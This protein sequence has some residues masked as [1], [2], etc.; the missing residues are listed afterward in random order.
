MQIITILTSR[1]RF[2]QICAFLL[3]SLL[4]QNCRKD[5]IVTGIMQPVTI[6]NIFISAGNLPDE[7]Q[8]VLSFI[9]HENEKY[10]FLPSFI[11]RFGIP[12]W[13]HSKVIESPQS[14]VPAFERS[15]GSGSSSPII[16]QQESIVLIPFSLPGS[17]EIT[18]YLVSKVRDSM[19]DGV[20]F[21][22]IKNSEIFQSAVARAKVSKE[23]FVVEG[24]KFE[25]DMFG[26]ESFQVTDRS[27]FK[28]EIE[29][30]GK[31]PVLIQ[32][33][34]TE[35][36]STTSK[37]FN[38]SYWV[39][40]VVSICYKIWVSRDQGQLVG[41]SV[42]C[43]SAHHYKEVTICD[44][45]YSW[46]EIVDVVVGGGGSSVTQWWYTGACVNGPCGASSSTTS[47]NTSTYTSTVNAVASKLT[48][49]DSQREW[50]SRN[51]WEAN[52]IQSFLM[53]DMMAQP[54]IEEDVYAGT[55]TTEASL[56]AK[57]TLDLAM[58]GLVEG[59]YTAVAEPYL[60][61]CPTCPSMPGFTYMRYL[62]FEY[63][64]LKQENPTWT[65]TKIL[66][67]ANLN[68][69]HLVL[70][71]AGALPLA[72][73]L[74]DLGNAFLY[75]LEGDNTNAYLSALGAV[76]GLDWVKWAKYAKKTLNLSNGRK[77][78]LKWLSVDNIIY[79]GDRRQ[80]RRVLE[81][82]DGSP[83]IAHHVIP[84]E[85]KKHP[86]IQAAAKYINNP[87]HMNSKTNGWPISKS[88]HS[89]SHSTYN[90][91]I[92]QGL[93]QVFSKSPTLDP[94]ICSQEV[95][96]IIS[97]VRVALSSNNTNMN[98]NIVW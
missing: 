84:I 10:G 16:R 96:R 77:T 92:L 29:T 28:D 34:T 4:F 83:L 41:C 98:L 73:E 82:P 61:Y 65:N 6:D 51:N 64:M 89:T 25:H 11:S 68:V 75:K 18:G 60:K 54:P 49:N 23:R 55:V 59:P 78:T 36:D 27:L 37:D 48:L 3:L 40:T 97:K 9:K 94:K 56:A 5:A 20:K 15:L 50:L 58:N 90:A 57:I 14:K 72:G 80:L 88:Q 7:V 2:C 86:I 91:L 22:P 46:T 95:E 13:H 85:Y 33:K 30:K 35:V 43:S 62:S 19:V 12:S 53:E 45:Y 52:Q 66:L 63:A 32:F 67:H 24:M 44:D 47:A 81:I 39:P 31:W 21:I 93:E 26:F 74:F 1:S 87:F 8:T 79:F 69:L 42:G 17:F 38:Q 70:D 71:V 76:P